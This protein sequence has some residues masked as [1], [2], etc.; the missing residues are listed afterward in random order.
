MA[1]EGIIVAMRG[2]RAMEELKEIQDVVLAMNLSVRV[3]KRFVLPFS[4][5]DRTVIVFDSC[6]QCFT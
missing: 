1:P 5:A 6:P 2:G 4:Q 3:V